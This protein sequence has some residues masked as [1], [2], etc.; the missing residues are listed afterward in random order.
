MQHVQQEVIIIIINYHYHH[1]VG[2]WWVRYGRAWPSSSLCGG[3]SMDSCSTP[4]CAVERVLAD[5][6]TVTIA[7]QI[8][9][10]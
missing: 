7:L 8:V 2:W 1:H 4:G 10:R 3:D 5:T 9:C 6:A